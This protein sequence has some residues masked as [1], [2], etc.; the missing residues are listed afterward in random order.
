M[1]NYSQFAQIPQVLPKIL[2]ALGV[3]QNKRVLIK[4]DNTPDYDISEYLREIDTDYYFHNH[5]SFEDHFQSIVEAHFLEQFIFHYDGLKR[6]SEELN[7]SFDTSDHTEF[8]NRIYSLNPKK[9]PEYSF[10]LECDQFEFK[11]IRLASIDNI[12]KELFYEG[13]FFGNYETITP[14]D[15]SV[16]SLLDLIGVSFSNLPFYK[17]LLSECYLLKKESKYKLAFFLAYSALESFVNSESGTGNDEERLKDK[18]TNLYR[19][20]FPELE[21]HQMYSSVMNQ[22]YK[23]NNERNDIAHGTQQIDVSEDDLDSLLMFVLTM[24]SCYEFSLNKFDDLYA[25][26]TS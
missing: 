4:I 26:I 23:F 5:W 22:Y 25:K 24:I 15:W 10:P 19:A 2:T 3:I 16:Y 17:Q 18:V 21:K 12:D 13:A 8:I 11:N 6:A 1:L 20:R 9:L 14:L 7:L